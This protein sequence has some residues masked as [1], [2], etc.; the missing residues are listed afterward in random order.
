MTL[1][2]GPNGLEIDVPDVVASGLVGGG[3]AEYVIDPNAE[4]ETGG[5]SGDE[6]ADAAGQTDGDAN[7][8][9]E[10]QGTPDAPPPAKTAKG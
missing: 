10:A 6:S 4:T 1:V 7:G 5:E 2:K 9:A 8:Q 3:H